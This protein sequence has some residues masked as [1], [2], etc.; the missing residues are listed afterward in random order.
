MTDARVVRILLRQGGVISRRQAIA[1]GTSPKA[2]EYKL[3]SGEWVRVLRGVFRLAAV[4]LIWEMWLTAS[5]Q[6]GGPDAVVSHRAAARVLGLDGIESAPAELPVV[7]FRRS[8][9][10]RI[11]THTTDEIPSCDRVKVGHL[12]VTSATRTLIDL[13]T[14]VRRNVVD[15]ALEAALRMRRTSAEKLLRRLEA[16]GGPGRRGSGVLR[17]VLAERGEGP[18][19]G[20]VF[21]VR[22]SRLLVSGGLPRPIRQFEIWDRGQFIA[23]PDVVYPGEQVA[24]ECESLEHHGGKADFDHDLVRINELTAFGWR[25]IRVSWKQLTTRPAEVIR[26]VAKALSAGRRG[27]SALSPL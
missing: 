14:V 26:L 1:A 9:D 7:K 13:G 17:A 6:A 5:V 16:I 2:I 21:E 18:P 22:V 15:E 8:P 19:S 27:R 11:V 23:R 3:R 24:I 12:T 4:R 20:S 10:P 25:V